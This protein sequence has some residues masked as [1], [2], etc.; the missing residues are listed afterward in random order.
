MERQILNYPDLTMPNFKLNGISNAFGFLR[1]NQIKIFQK[2]P[3][4]H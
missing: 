4:K 1:V 2:C 3:V